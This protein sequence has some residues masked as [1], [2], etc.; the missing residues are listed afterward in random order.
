MSAPATYQHPL[1]L[2]T[3]NLSARHTLLSNELWSLVKEPQALV[4]DVMV[5]V[6]PVP[7]IFRHRLGSHALCEIRVLH[8]FQHIGFEGL[9]IIRLILFIRYIILTL[10]ILACAQNAHSDS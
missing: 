8:L 1:N 2:S 9:T 10:R 7:A 5:H 3:T 6:G 4:V